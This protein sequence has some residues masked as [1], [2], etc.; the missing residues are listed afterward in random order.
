[1]VINLGKRKGVS[2]FE[3]GISGV[4]AIEGGERGGGNK[5]FDKPE[6][7]AD[8]ELDYTLPNYTSLNTGRQKG[9]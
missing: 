6:R 3:R 1:M 5:Y 2:E 7:L 4:G 9:Q 8:L